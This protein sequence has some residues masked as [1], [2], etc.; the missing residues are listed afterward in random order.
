MKYL[1][2]FFLIASLNYAYSQSSDEFYGALRL[3]DSTVITYR[4]NFTI[5]KGSLKGYSITDLGGKYETKSEI[6]GTYNEKDNLIS[7]KEISLIYTKSDFQDDSFCNVHLEPTKFKHGKTKH[8]SGNFQ[9]KFS[10]GTA[11][12]NG[13]AFFNSTKNIKKKLNKISK[14]AIKSKF[15]PDSLKLKMKKL[16]VLDSLGLNVLK[17]DEITSIPTS[18]KSLKLFIYD[19]GQIDNDVVSVYLNDIALLSKYSISADKKVLTVKLEDKKTQIKILSNSVGSIGS[20]TAMIKIIDGDNTIKAMTN[21]KKG[22]ITKIDIL[23][24]N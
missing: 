15:V 22:E 2:Y 7:F 13:E 8:F 21:L 12:I 24:R 9:G 1:K 3:S 23:K 17:K 11:C 20:N 16:N 4:I 6:I 10:D 19:G 18:S 5:S 14:K